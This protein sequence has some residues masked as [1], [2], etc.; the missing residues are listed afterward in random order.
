MTLDYMIILK[1]GAKTLLLISLLMSQIADA[2]QARRFIEKSGKS[3][4]IVITEE[5]EDE[6]PLY[7]KLKQHFKSKYLSIGAWLRSDFEYQQSR[8]NEEDNG[9]EISR[10]RLTFGGELDG[11]MGYV[12]QSDFF[13]SPSILDAKIYY[14]ISESFTIDVGQFKAPFS[15]EVLRSGA[16]RDFVRAASLAVLAPRRQIGVQFRGWIRQDLISYAVGI[17]NG[18]GRVNDN[19]N[20]KFMYVARI[21][22]SGQPLVGLPLGF[23]DVEEDDKKVDLGLNIAFSEDDDVEIPSLVSNFSGKRFLVG[24][25]SRLRRGK[26][27]LSGEVIYAHLDQE[28]GASKKPFGYHVTSGYVLNPKTRILVRFDNLQTDGLDDDTSFLI[29]SYSHRPT[30]VTRLQVNYGID[31]DNRAFDKNRFF[32]SFQFRF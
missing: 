4:M 2:A 29:F 31:L 15:G 10:F 14:R 3:E 17:F 20:G 7:E 12:M 18:N 1:R 32:C 5:T 21:T 30:K 8:N 6:E 13:L 11:G 25:D 9:F 23:L 27:L 26:M 22:Y 16:D 19:D 24:V 28:T